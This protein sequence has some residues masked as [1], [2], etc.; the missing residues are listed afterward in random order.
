MRIQER[1]SEL[2]IVR[3]TYDSNARLAKYETNTL[4]WDSQHQLLQLSRGASGQFSYGALGM[5]SRKS[6]DGAAKQ[7]D[8]LRTRQELRDGSG[9]VVSAEYRVQSRWHESNGRF[10][11]IAQDSIDLFG[12]CN[13]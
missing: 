4:V 10:F 13:P 8:E 5:R 1:A 2:T 3:H 7:L 9:L 12:A 6:T 11:T